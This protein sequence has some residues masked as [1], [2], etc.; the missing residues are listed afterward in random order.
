MMQLVFDKEDCGPIK[1][2][3]IYEQKG[4]VQ[5]PVVYLRKPRTTDK[6]TFDKVVEI[7][8]NRLCTN[9]KSK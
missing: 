8:R 2:P 5:Y 1:G 4:N 3:V 9:I 6:E 7:L